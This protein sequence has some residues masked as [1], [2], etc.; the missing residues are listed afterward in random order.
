ML[1]LICILRDKKEGTQAINLFSYYDHL[2]LHSSVIYI[3]S[4]AYIMCIKFS[5]FLA[6]SPM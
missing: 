3:V 1:H 2:L 6:T 5:N 4:L